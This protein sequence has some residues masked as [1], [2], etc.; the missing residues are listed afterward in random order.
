MLLSTGMNPLNAIQLCNA[1][2]RRIGIVLLERLRALQPEREREF[3]IV[4]IKTKREKELQYSSIRGFTSSRRR[5][6][7][8]VRLGEKYNRV[9]VPNPECGSRSSLPREKKNRTF[10]VIR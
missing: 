8:S 9:S 3:T 4:L 1:L 7:R 10:L 5:L 2:Y 6:V